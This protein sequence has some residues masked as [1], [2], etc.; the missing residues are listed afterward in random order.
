MPKKTIKSAQ[1]PVRDNPGEK[2]KKAKKGRSGKKARKP[3][4]Q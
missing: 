3:R 4:S 2:A 1:P